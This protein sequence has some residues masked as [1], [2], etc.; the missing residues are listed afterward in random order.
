[1]RGG[2]LWIYHNDGELMDDTMAVT[3]AMDGAIT[4]MGTMVVG[5]MVVGTMVVG[6]M[7]VV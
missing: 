4:V 3:C 7:V 2:A 5:I 1:M 6:T